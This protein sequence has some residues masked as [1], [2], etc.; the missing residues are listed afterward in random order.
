M[1][2]ATSWKPALYHT[3][4]P[5]ISVRGAV[6]AIEF[7]KKAFGA[8][9]LYRMPGPDGRI[10]HAELRIGDSV[11]MLADENPEMGATSPATLGGST[12]GL[13]IYVESC[14]H[15]FQRAVQAGATA[16]MPPMDMFWGDRYGTL[17][18]PFGHRWSIG[19]HLRD[20]T[21]QEIIAASEAWMKQQAQQKKA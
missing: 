21:P 2:K 18:D 9:E 20:M 5:Y 14:D 1:S 10:M 15:A 19:T 8:E 12:A 17:K 16:E 11:V 4:T 3:V 13:M 6:Q 7:Y